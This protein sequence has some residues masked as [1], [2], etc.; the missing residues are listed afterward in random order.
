MTALCKALEVTTSGYYAWRKR[1]PSRRALEDKRLGVLVEDSHHASRKNYGS[2]RVHRDLRASGERVSRKRVIR[3]MRD[4]G[5][6]GKVRRRWVTTTDSRHDQPVA[7]NVL[8]QQFAAAAPNE[9]WVGDVTYL[10]TPEGWLYLAVILDLFSRRV[11]GWALSPFND[12]WLAL[13]ALEM[14]VSQRRPK[15]G[16]IH[17]T[18]Q[19]S[20]YA[21]SDYQKVLERHG[22]RCSMS[23]R[24]NCYDNAVAESWFGMF[25]TELGET[26]ESFADAKHKVFDYIEGFYNTRRRHSALDYQSPAEF[27]R[28]VAA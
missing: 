4:R 18:D 7:P 22:M 23:R 2:P 21:S 11:V 24:G 15:S 17:H 25:K 14:A 12:R 6:Q 26:F 1:A 27:E 20:P 10:R 3:L 5:L 9:R 28:T 16:L 8:G 13:R 19:G